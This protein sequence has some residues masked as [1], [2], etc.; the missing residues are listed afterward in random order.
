MPDK[1]ED[2]TEI[3]FTDTVVPRRASHWRQ[4]KN[5]GVPQVRFAKISSNGML[6][7]RLLPIFAKYAIRDP[8]GMADRHQLSEAGLLLADSCR[9]HKLAKEKLEGYED[10]R[11][12]GPINN[13]L[14]HQDK[15]RGTDHATTLPVMMAHYGHLLAEPGIHQFKSKRFR[16]FQEDFTKLWNSKRK[17][18]HSF[19]LPLAR[20]M[21][22][23]GN[24]ERETKKAIESA[25]SI[26]KAPGV[27]L[28]RRDAEETVRMVR[29]QFASRGQTGGEWLRLNTIE[30]LPLTVDLGKLEVRETI[31]SDHGVV[32]KRISNF[33]QSGNIFERVYPE[34]GGTILIDGSG[35]MGMDMSDI[36]ELVKL[37]PAATVAVYSAG[38]CELHNYRTSAS[39]ITDGANCGHLAIVA[40]D[41]RAYNIS[42]AGHDFRVGGGNGIDGLA[43]KW[44]AKQ[45]EPRFWISD[46][47]VVGAMYDSTGHYLDYAFTTEL[48]DE[49]IAT[50]K[51]NNI[52]WVYCRGDVSEALKGLAKLL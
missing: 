47:M 44:L 10:S 34:K 30:L 5:S 35:S 52:D 15:P 42:T 6:S 48:F 4:G 40:K 26:M 29:S 33:C 3:G 32:P 21:E 18:V 49:C 46:G 13:W 27:G 22:E 23:F 45:E 24:P 43:L 12:R 17:G 38:H 36:M 8:E 37:A 16:K 14:A 20:M 2:L 19:T 7:R 39:P 1:E 25:A 28:S 41:G 9:M 11:D 31:F 50:C 51:T